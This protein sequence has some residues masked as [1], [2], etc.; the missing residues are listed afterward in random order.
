MTGSEFGGLSDKETL[1]WPLVSANQLGLKGEAEN[2][3]QNV[4]LRMQITVGVNG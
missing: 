3:M 1:N 2:Y 4:A